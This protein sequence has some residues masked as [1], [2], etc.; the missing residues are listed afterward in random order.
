M[1]FASLLSTSQTAR[2]W[3]SVVWAPLPLPGFASSA[4][5]RRGG[6]G[7]ECSLRQIPRNCVLYSPGIGLPTYVTMLTSA[8]SVHQAASCRKG[9]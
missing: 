6:A 1:L 5:S 4:A 7:V 2:R 9:S 8:A 3:L